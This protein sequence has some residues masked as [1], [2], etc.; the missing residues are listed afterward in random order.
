MALKKKRKWY[1]YISGMDE[2]KLVKI[3]KDD[4][5]PQRKNTSRPRKNGAITSPLTEIRLKGEEGTGNRNRTHVRTKIK[6]EEE[7]EEEEFFSKFIFIQLFYWTFAI[8]V[9]KNGSDLC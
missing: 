4:S 2:R 3:A 1:D 6:K 9:F 7:E 8:V 5:L